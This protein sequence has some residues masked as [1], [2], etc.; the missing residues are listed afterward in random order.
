M[1]TII[2]AVLSLV[3]IALL[4]TIIWWFIPARTPSISSNSNQSIASLEY[5]EIGGLQQSI[6]IRSENTSNPILLLLH[7]GPGMPMMYLA[8]TFQIP[9]EQEFTVVQWD[10]RGAGKTF[11]KNKPDPESIN[12]RQLM[13]D[14]Y[15][16]ID[17][18]RNKYHQEK[19][20]L[21]GHS[22]GTYLGSLMVTER[23]ELF[24]AYISIGQVVDDTKAYQIQRQFVME[25]A[26][27]AGDEEIV[28]ALNNKPSMNL[29]SCLF[30]HG[31]EIKSSTSYFP[32]IRN[33][34]KAPEYS[35]PEVM[36]VAQGSQFSSEN[37]KYNIINGSIQEEIKAYP[38]PTYFF[39]GR[40]DYTTP[41]ELVK[42]YHDSIKAPKKQLV[43]FDESAHFPF[44]EEPI[45]FTEEVIRI[46]EELRI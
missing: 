11:Y 4:A 5:I 38:I 28:K 34:M 13:D 17:T 36:S 19:I 2:K 9:L 29:E 46:K 35:L 43:I 3:I 31:G 10:R 16:L 12:I 26:L 32:L 24:Y 44:F 7:G 18:L 15:N 20:L 21:A 40:H 37:M 8:H 23:P 27:E 33:G 42:E 14:A 22:F 39:I 6:L 45:K 30:A 41:Y 25:K 1:K